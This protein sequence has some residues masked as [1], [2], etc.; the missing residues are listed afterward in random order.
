VTVIQLAA[1]QLLA[2]AGG[3][4]GASPY[5]EAQRAIADGKAFCHYS[6]A[7][8]APLAWQEGC[9][10]ERGAHLGSFTVDGEKRPIIFAHAPCA[11]RYCFRVH[12]KE[13]LVLGFSVAPQVWDEPGGDGV[14]FHVEVEGTEGEPQIVFERYIDPRSS[15]SDR[16]WHDIEIPLERWANRDIALRLMTSPGPLR[17]GTND[18]AGWSLPR[19]IS[20]VPPPPAPHVLVVTVA[21]LALEADSLLPSLS[22]D[23][24]ASQGASC[25]V[26]FSGTVKEDPYSLGPLAEALASRGYRTLAAA[27]SPEARAIEDF[28]VKKVSPQ[29]VIEAL[30]WVNLHMER[31][32]LIWTHTQLGETAPLDTLDARLHRLLGTIAAAGMEDKC[33]LVVAGHP[34]VGTASGARHPLLIR[35]LAEVSSDVRIR[36]DVSPEDLL[37]TLLDLVRAGADRS[38]PGRSVL[39]FLKGL[40][41]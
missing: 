36:E 10:G 7:A 6:L 20:P 8:M 32:F 9:P 15:V 28:E 40:V 2:L 16:C 22:L 35:H 4:G 34:A 14:G 37:P 3:T 17:D 23:I 26:T 27:G 24:L 25:A 11:L 33:V 30:H 41:R 31:T 38:L 39:P 12:P 29:P 21:G 1:L 5:A 18:W 19:T 13:R